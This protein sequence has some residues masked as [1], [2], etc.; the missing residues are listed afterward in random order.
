[1]LP[2]LLQDM[3]KE[4]KNISWLVENFA[5]GKGS[6]IENF[7][8]IMS[9]KITIDTPTH[10]TNIQITHVVENATNYEN[11]DG[12]LELIELMYEN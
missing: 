3:K 2:Y 1:M 4:K 12:V 5:V 6:D 11:D 9:A 10:Q 7:I 8:I